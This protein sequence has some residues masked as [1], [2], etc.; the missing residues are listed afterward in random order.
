MIQNNPQTEKRHSPQLSNVFTLGMAHG[1]NEKN[2]GFNETY[3]PATDRT[4]E[5]IKNTFSLLHKTHRC[6]TVVSSPF[7]H[8]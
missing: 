1:G 2:E 6:M 7:E 8:S 3:L 4:K 5:S